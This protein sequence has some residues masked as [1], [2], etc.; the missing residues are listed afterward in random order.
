MKIS[1]NLSAATFASYV[2]L[3]VSQFESVKDDTM[4]D[5]DP[6]KL[7]MLDT[8][9]SVKVTD[10]ERD[11]EEKRNQKKQKKKEHKH[12]HRHHTASEEEEAE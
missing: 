9:I 7:Q 5:I 3:L 8:N 11:Y 4:H 1:T 6:I 2:D 12:K 10:I